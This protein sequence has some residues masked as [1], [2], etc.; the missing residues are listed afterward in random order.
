MFKFHLRQSSFPFCILYDIACN[1]VYDIVGKNHEQYYC[2]FSCWIRSRHNIKH[3]ED[4]PGTYS[5]SYTVS[6][7]IVLIKLAHTRA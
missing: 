1:I 2:I 7:K 6:Y 5:I 3:C 4:P